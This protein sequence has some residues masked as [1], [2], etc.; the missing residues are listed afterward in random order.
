MAGVGEG[1]LAQRWSGVDAPALRETY[2]LNRLSI[3]SKT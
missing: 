3:P 2:A 1:R